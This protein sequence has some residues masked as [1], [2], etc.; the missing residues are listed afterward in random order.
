MIHLVSFSA[1]TWNFPL[2]GRTRMLAEAWQR[3]GVPTTFVQ[4]PYLR[5]A[6][7]RLWP[8]G[9]QAE[10]V[11]VMRPWPV[12][13]RRLW[14]RMGAAHLRPVIQ[15]RARGL[16]RQLDP[17]VTWDQAAAVVVS[18]VWAP[19][20]EALPFRRV[21]YDC[22]DA[23]EVH[24][25]R[26]ELAPLYQTW[27]TELLQRCGGVVVTAA[28]LGRAIHARRADL[29][30]ATIRN[31]VDV[32]RFERLAAST[33]MPGDLPQRGRPIVG[34]VGV[35]SGGATYEWLDWELLTRVIRTLPE[36]DFV[37]V[38]PHDRNAHV[39]AL[40]ALPNAHLLGWRPYELVP[41][42]VNAC[43]VCWVPFSQGTVGHAANPVKIYEYLSLGKPV[44]TTPVSDTGSFGGL[45]AVARSAEEMADQLRAAVQEGADRAEARLAFARANSWETR[46]RAFAD[47]A[48]GLSPTVAP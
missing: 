41:A 7:E 33:P 44:V 20:L 48:E 38:G 13:P 40:R 34:F 5:S 47:F 25:P 4:A 12:Y 42:Y 28:E 14:P 30:I 21:I 24:V 3:L 36:F 22:I 27:E 43:D 37:F 19:W 1:V 6:L 32:E 46:A 8:F 23:V 11:R 45:V 29:P 39:D 31:G 26:A 16:R 35:M 15:R 2:I 17:I 18:P 9:R 10:A